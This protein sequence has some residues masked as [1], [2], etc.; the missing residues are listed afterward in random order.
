M[1]VFSLFLAFLMIGMLSFGG[2]YAMLPLF[3]RVIVLENAWLSKE[4][5]IDMIA[6][7]QITPGPIAIN[8]ATFIGFQIAGIPGALVSTIGMMSIPVILV[9]IVSFYQK[10]FLESKT[11]KAI[12]TGLRP[13]LIGL[14]MASV[15]SVAQT[16][17]FDWISLLL[18]GVILVSL[19]KFKVHP[20]TVIIAS[21]LIGLIVFL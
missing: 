21:G 9:S 3:E 1:I 15:F 2:G 4:M 13:A 20:I 10:Q 7:S 14:I 18:F 8:S 17:L 16:A 12:F 6:L 11:V 5:F 19:L